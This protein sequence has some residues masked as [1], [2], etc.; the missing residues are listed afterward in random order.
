MVLRWKK[1]QGIWVLTKIYKSSKLP[2]LA[3]LELSLKGL[4]KLLRKLFTNA[5]NVS[6]DSQCRV[7]QSSSHTIQLYYRLSEHWII[8]CTIPLPIQPC[9]H[10]YIVFTNNMAYSK[11]CNL[12]SSQG[13]L[14]DLIWPIYGSKFLYLRAKVIVQVDQNAKCELNSKGFRVNA[15]NFATL[16]RLAQFTQSKWIEA[17]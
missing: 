2:R 17:F 10:K 6:E 7:P 9:R 15:D 1:N 16:M 12:R 8:C 5:V 3:G 11:D 4:R 13:L 14:K